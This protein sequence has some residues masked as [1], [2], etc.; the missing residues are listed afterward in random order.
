MRT[1]ASGTLFS[2]H[3]GKKKRQ[4]SISLV[5]L[6]LPF[7]VHITI[8]C[9]TG[10]S[11]LM[12]EGDIIHQDGSSLVHRLQLSSILNILVEFLVGGSLNPGPCVY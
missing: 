8:M 5:G 1:Q 6:V 12:E 3:L 4:N 11:T 10:R 7:P 9:G 2:G